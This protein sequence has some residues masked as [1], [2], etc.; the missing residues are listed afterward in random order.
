[1]SAAA[2]TGLTLW[3]LSRPVA[4]VWHALRH[5][6]AMQLRYAVLFWL[7]WGLTVG[8]QMMSGYPD[9]DWWVPIV[10]GL[11]D[12]LLIALL[13][14]LGIAI[15]DACPPG[16]WPWLPYAI[17]AVA[18][19]V[20]GT[21]LMVLTE[22]MV[23][24]QCCWDGPRP[25]NWIFIGAGLGTNF[26]VCGLAAFSYYY[27]RRALQRVNALQA[28]Q[29]RRAELARR[30]FEARLQAMQARVEPQFLF[31]TLS[32]VERLYEVNTTMAD[33]MLDD[34]IVY[35][36][37][38]LPQLR[39]TTSTVARE[40]D[41][42]RAYFNIAKAQLADRLSLDTA[43]P[44]GGSDARFPPMIL[45]PLI[46]HAI[47][48]RLESPL[49]GG[50]IGIDWRVTGDK[51]RLTVTDKGGS[52]IQAHAGSLPIAGIRERLTALYGKAASLTLYRAP[53]RTSRTVVE[54]PHERFDDRTH[55]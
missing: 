2:G 9:Y 50:S 33:R 12:S 43:E 32:H 35:L 24:I 3:S 16:T 26:V 37:A 49:T 34:L 42:I 6:T 17:A 45:L 22:P 51:L 15:A 14:L 40:I 54:I 31:N 39:E 36:R 53:D 21:V 47:L 29:L 30:T 19:N 11:Y 20:L 44:H 13:L 25:S 38:A 1:M 18:A 46:E 55:R 41:L 7:A 4:F 5:I 28:E 48:A 52:S 27:R 8:L 10:T 23:G